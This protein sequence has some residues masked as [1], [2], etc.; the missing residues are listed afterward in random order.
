MN[1]SIIVPFFNPKEEY[2]STLISEFLLLNPGHFEVIFVNDGSSD[3]T[4]SIL[5]PIAESD[6]HVRLINFSKNFGHE[7][8]MIAG[9]DYAK[10][11][12]IIC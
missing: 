7:S 12:A 2:V 6:E 4:L 10:S 11:N 5:K 9:I 8:A 3:N 1:I